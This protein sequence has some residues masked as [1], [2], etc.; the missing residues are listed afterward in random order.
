M[1]SDLTFIQGVEYEYDPTLRRCQGHGP[2][3]ICKQ[4]TLK[5][6][7]YLA[8]F[9]Q[10]FRFYSNYFLPRIEF[11]VPQLASVVSAKVKTSDTPVLVTFLR[12][13]RIRTF[14]CFKG[15]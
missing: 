3:S 12:K 14:N 2:T 11:I 8:H 4:K 9:I 10:F 13:S 7:P 15:T 1:E 5:L 6:L